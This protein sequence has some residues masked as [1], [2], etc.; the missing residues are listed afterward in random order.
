[1][2]KLLLRYGVLLLLFVGL[3]G[4]EARASHLLGGE[5]TYSYLGAL[6]PAATPF[7]YRVT[8]LIYVNAGPTSSVPDGRTSIT[9]NFYNKSQNNGLIRT[10]SLPRISN[11]L[12]V[13]PGCTSAGSPVQVRLCRYE[14]TVDLPVSFDG[15][16]AVYTDGTRNLGITNLRVPSDSQQQTIYIE[17]APPL[18]PNTSPTFS[19]TAVVV[20]CQN[21]TTLLL[22]NA[23]DPNGDR[24]VYSLV[25]PFNQLN[26]V[27][28]FSTP[29]PVTYAAGY[30]PTT[31]F[32]TT[33]G[34]YAALN[35]STGLAT[36]ASAQLGN[37]VA[38][39]EV[40]E[41]R[42]INGQE[43]LIGS[44][45]REVQLVVRTCPPNNSPQFTPGSVAQHTY[46]VQ[47]GQ[48]MS[49]TIA[50]TDADR[51]PIT[52]RAN[53]VLLDGA[54]GFNSTFAGQPG[55]VLPGALTGSATTSGTNGAVSG[56]FNFTPRCGDARATPY[57]VVVT[58]TDAVNCN[59][60]TVADVFQIFV[61][62]APA[63]TALTGDSVICD[64]TQL[65]TYTAAGPTPANG[66]SWRVYGGSIQGPAN[67][68]SIQVRW[69]GTGQGRVTVRNLSAFGCQSDSVSRAINIR[70]ASTLAV[71]AAS[72]SICAGQSTTLTASGG[73]TY[74]WTGGSQP[75][76]GT[77]VTV[78]PTQTT[79]YTV[80]SSDGVC[81]TTRQV[82]VT[83]N[84]VA[85][86]N[87][88][89]AVSFCAGG[90]GQLGASAVAGYT[91]QWS[92]TT[93]L[94][95]AT[96][97]NPTVTLPNTGTT[98]LTQTYTLTATTAAGCVATATVV[99]TVNPL[100]ALNPGTQ[101]TVCSGQPAT[102]SGAT[103]VAGVTYAWTST[104]L[105][106]LND[107]NSPTPT[108][109]VVNTT[110]APIVRTYTLTAT[111]AAAIGGCQ[112]TATFTL[113]VNPAAV[114]DAGADVTP[115]SGISATLG[116][117]GLTG[118]S[119][120]WSP[121]TGL[122]SA[123]V[124]QPTFNQTLPAGSA[125]QT[126]TY[127][128]TATTPQGCTATD[129][130]TVTLN[131]AA[132][133]TAG[134]DRTICTGTTTQIGAAGLTGYSYSWSPATGLSSAT[135]A[136]PTVTLPNASTTTVLTQQYILT[137]TNSF[138][139]VARDTV[140]VNV[141][142]TVVATAGANRAV[143]SGVSTTLGA[144]A[145]TGY[146]Y[147]WS[148]ATG[149]S[150]A[151]V[152]NPTFSQTL[153]AG[154]APQTLTFTVT[155]TSPQNCT[156][157]SQVTVTLNPAATANAGAPV[158]V[159]SGKSV[160][161]GTAALP[162]YSYSWSPATGLSS[163]TAAQPT[164]SQTIAPG[165]PSQTLTYTLTATTPQGCA[166][167]SSV[168]VTLNSRPETDSIRGTASVCPTVQGVNYSIR[169]PRASAYQWTV[170]GGTIASG[171]GTAS[172]TVDWGP[173]T[174]G[175]NVKA[176]R[177]NQF[178]CSSDTVTFPVRINPI[179]LTARPTGPARVCQADGPYTYNTQQTA[180]STY[181]WQIIGGTQVSTTGASV[182]VNWTRAG[183]GKIVVTESS[184]PAG[185]RCLGTSDTLFVTVL[186]SP[187]AQ[188]ISGPARFCFG[189]SG[190]YSVPNVTGSTYRW[191]L[192][193]G[194]AP[195]TT[196]NSVTLT[197][198]AAGTYTLTVT[199]TNSAACAGPVATRTFTVDP[200][201]AAPAV[202]GPRAIC[203]EGLSGVAYSIGS[204]SSTSS[205][206]WTVTGGSITS[207]QG[208]GAVSVNFSPTA[209]TRSVVVTET[210]QFGCAGPATTIVLPLDNASV[211][212]N[213][214]SVDQASDRKITLALN[215]ADRSNN[216]NQVRVLRR[217][218]GTGAFTQIA[219]VANSA[220]SYDDTSVD[221]DATAY[222]Y[223]L[224]LVNSCGTV[225]SSTSHTTMRLEVTGAQAGAGRAQ[226]Q[227]SLRW[228]AYQGFPVQQYE[229]YRQ[230]DGGAAERVQ[231]VP[232]TAASSYSLS[233]ATSAAGFDQHYRVKAV[234]TVAGLTSFSN[235]TSRAFANTLEFYNVI[236]P[237]GDNLNDQLVIKNVEL[238]PGNTLAIFNR[239]GREIYRTT[240]YRNT[241][242]GDAQPA[243]TYY[244]MFTDN[245]GK[246]TKGWFEI[247][248]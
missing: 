130:V 95:S 131:P 103:A 248:R 200:L 89:N 229:V 184:N 233:F 175:A 56:T 135:A 102:L 190:T 50:A 243:G 35:A 177:L 127:T 100:P 246:V 153:A 121:A 151:T 231:V 30:G 208:S 39:V 150:S 197:G 227:V 191:T 75:L 101:Q 19:D 32:G 206:Q 146:T 152:A 155:A 115:C 157:T 29:T 132:T 180:G 201:P 107:P 13:P 88:G 53:S 193:G 174:T 113:T 94:S 78:A 59:S 22:N 245:A 110:G 185:G 204:A 118:Y 20:V 217:N 192:T 237:N 45:R 182:V 119:Y 210:T 41:Y 187:V 69:A 166:A 16:Y 97:A 170:T 120:S 198:L 240:N 148:P 215:V 18:L 5:M 122:S 10:V 31:P 6:G 203:P 111:N 234:S 181:G 21:D 26:N 112:R 58:A 96:T 138:G 46:T 230:A 85:V 80:T 83:V 93:G 209:T 207:G 61:T 37:F 143:C 247:M 179:L 44:I 141:N 129:Q 63:P 241:W 183:I 54:G 114:A 70:P 167:T 202:T 139:C 17:M 162:G 188:Q 3:A 216:A 228:N 124:A 128:V 160:P 99:V 142:P 125:P 159:C 242:G 90:S 79:T 173:A 212:L 65:R 108:A 219:T 205:Y 235:E 140:V 163:A 42:T 51:N 68:S 123:T 4:P 84:P 57:D 109:T 74:T 106:D 169:N 236:T 149:L 47:E 144:A 9:V 67:G 91:Y 66:Y 164:F 27:N 156:A 62:R 28:I 161:L 87:A 145:L 239:W 171:Q 221:A 223:R 176:F 2:L 7:R 98:P 222:D 23:V 225:L 8:V 168:V 116:T 1:M 11:P 186:P 43:V 195:T 77:T 71:T 126:I 158:A 194:P 172:I 72:A 49:F 220:S 178:G 104:T 38:S 117:A 218:A 105:G 137:A 36:Y 34:N 92:P 224:D 232:A 64:A 81:T 133:A 25:T 189:T 238:Y 134:P 244:F 199:E 165:A 48:P 154:S 40:K 52:L 211:S 136:Q 33:T 55:T 14:T 73:T 76:S 213:T 12:I 82:T 214:A 226:D 147:S 196:G 24:L 60:K 86:A 15:Y